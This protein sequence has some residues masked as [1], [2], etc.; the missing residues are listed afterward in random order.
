MKRAV[1]SRRSRCPATDMPRLGR[2][3]RRTS[4]DAIPCEP[5]AAD[6][7]SGAR[8]SVRSRSGETALDADSA[9]AP[10]RTRR[11]RIS[12]R[13]PRSGLALSPPSVAT[14]AGPSGPPWGPSAADRAPSA[15]A[16]GPIGTQPIGSRAV[17]RLTSELADLEFA[18]SPHPRTFPSRHDPTGTTAR[19]WAVRIVSQRLSRAAHPIRRSHDA[20]TIDHV[21][22]ANPRPRPHP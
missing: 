10:N 6:D 8:R 2:P 1:G 11:V 19:S 14:L 13:I 18:S 16:R 22:P 12:A 21:P 15:T 3:R 9:E 7:R 5:R 4:R 17:A 20:T